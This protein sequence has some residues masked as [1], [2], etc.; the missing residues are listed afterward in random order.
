MD[1]D[2]RRD[3]FTKLVLPEEVKD[4]LEAISCSY[5]RAKDSSKKLDA[6]LIKGKGEGK[7][8]LLHG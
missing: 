8:F 5:A 2:F 3:A 7:I 4:T 6:D 1:T